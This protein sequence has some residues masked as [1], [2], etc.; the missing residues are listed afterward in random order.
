MS[1]RKEIIN[2]HIIVSTPWAVI[3]A[4]AGQDFIV[5]VARSITVEVSLPI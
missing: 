1:V 4:A 3:T 2:V 5:L